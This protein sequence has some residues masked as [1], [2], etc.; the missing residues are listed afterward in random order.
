[1]SNILDKISSTELTAQDNSTVEKTTEIEQY[2]NKLKGLELLIKNM[3]LCNVFYRKN[4]KG[5]TVGETFV[6]LVDYMNLEINF[7]N[8]IQV[9]KRNLTKGYGT[10][11]PFQSWEL[12]NANGRRKQTESRIKQ[13]TAKL[14]KESNT[15][16]ICNGLDFKTNYEDDRYRLHFD[17]KP[18]E[19]IRTL[20]K[21]SMGLKW[22]PRN[23]AWQRKITPNAKWSIDRHLNE[24]IILLSQ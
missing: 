16:E 22:S 4:S 5:K 23:E 1:M 18:S 2:E 14:G 19:E 9:A 15:V 21:R 24:L 20:L 3:K 8:H 13:L 11:K 7:G 17:G 6:L 12:T 10:V